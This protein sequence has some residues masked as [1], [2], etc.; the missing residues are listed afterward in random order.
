MP[1]ESQLLHDDGRW[2]RRA[3]ALLLAGAALYLLGGLAAPSLAGAAGR[4]SGLGRLLLEWRASLWDG[5]VIL[6]A[7]ALL[8]PCVDAL[9]PS[10]LRRWIDPATPEALG[11]MR[12]LVAGVLLA[13]ALWED[14]P[15]TAY[16]P[17]E[18]LAHRPQW[19]VEWLLRVPGMDAFFAG[20]AA[21][22]AFEA[23]AIALLAM[24]AVGLGTRWTVPAAAVAYLLMAATL[25][26]YAYSYH[27]GIAPLYALLLLSLTPCGD[28]WSADRWLRMRRGQPVPPAREPAL[29]YGIG[30]YLVWMAVALPYLFAGLSKLRG[31][32]PFWWNA[33]QMKQMVVATAVEPRQF[34]FELAFLL[35]RAPD[36]TWSALGLAAL[37]AELAF[38][39]VLVSRTARRWL[40]ALM[41]GMHVGILLT[42]NIFFPD[43]IALQAVFYDWRPLR[44][45]LFGRRAAAGAHAPP[46]RP[47]RVLRRAPLAFVLVLWIAWAARIERFPLT[48]MR[49]FSRPLPAEP[50]EYVRAWVV[51]ADGSRERARLERWIP[52]MADTRYRPLLRRWDRRP[53]RVPLLRALLDAAAARANA[54]APPGRRVARFELEQ[55]RWDFRRDPRAPEQGELLRVVRHEVE[56]GGGS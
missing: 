5:V 25:R 52:A 10:K 20:H 30:R 4:G 23:A 7:A 1:Q 53:E 51:Y 38:V 17:R 36:W 55:R 16:L 44:D 14:L 6:A 12:M 18:L 56:P 27:T 2:T 40:P 35:L 33:E 48:A 43:L 45:R 50:V 13:S 46:P 54:G 47:G 41:A 21:L 28:A 3:A 34:D 19:V 8:A 37:A 15:S 29:R 49:M 11:A 42:Q 39:L 26:S 31:T 9:R 24:A 32:G 22:T